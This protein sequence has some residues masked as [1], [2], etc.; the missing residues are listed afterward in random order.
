ML[1]QACNIFNINYC[2]VKSRIN[3]KKESPQ[4]AFDHFYKKN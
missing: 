2:S 1:K 3:A 4:D